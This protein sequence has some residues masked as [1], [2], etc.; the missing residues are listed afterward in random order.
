MASCVLKGVKPSSKRYRITE[1]TEEWQQ[2][3]FSFHNSDLYPWFLRFFH[4]NSII[5]WLKKTAFQFIY[6]SAISQRMKLKWHTYIL[7]LSHTHSS[8][9]WALRN[10]LVKARMRFHLLPV[11]MVIIPQSR[12][13]AGKDVGETVIYCWWQCSLVQPSQKTGFIQTEWN[14]HGRVICTTVLLAAQ[15][16]RAKKME[17]IQMTISGWLDKENVEI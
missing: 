2:L 7:S 10:M 9:S 1:Y 5:K 14:Q 6:S 12:N 4:S 11:R 16:T 13:S 3:S 15:L 8:V 17:L